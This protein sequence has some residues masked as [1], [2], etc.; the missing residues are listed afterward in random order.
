M[1]EDAL[2]VR[3][4]KFGQPMVCKCGHQLTRG[5]VR[6]SD[7]RCEIVCSSCHALVVE[8]ECDIE[9]SYAW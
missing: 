9:R 7:D 1:S 8:I 6:A 3:A 4:V 5:D 2:E